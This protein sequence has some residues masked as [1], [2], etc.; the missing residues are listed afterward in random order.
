[1]L[2]CYSQKSTINDVAIGGLCCTCK[3][4]DY[5]PPHLDNPHSHLRFYSRHNTA[6]P[7]NGT[8]FFS[9]CNAHP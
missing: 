2:D 7:L 1:M 8:A 6:V 3:D 5:D 9:I 4:D